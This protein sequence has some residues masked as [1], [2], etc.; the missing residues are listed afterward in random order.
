M[1]FI[2]TKVSWERQRSG[3]CIIMLT[4]TK[5]YTFTRKH[6][7]MFIIIVILT[8]ELGTWL[9]HGA[10]AEGVFGRYMSQKWHFGHGITLL[11]DIVKPSYTQCQK[12]QLFD[13]E[14]KVI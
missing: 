8:M 7:C 3:S 5:T 11:F 2:V 14:N 1:I 9:V 13:I 12:M 10:I 4:M 6:S